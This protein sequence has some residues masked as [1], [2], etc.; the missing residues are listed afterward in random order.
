MSGQIDR[1]FGKTYCLP[2]CHLTN[3]AE[4]LSIPS[5]C[6]CLNHWNIV[7]GKA[8]VPFSVCWGTEE[9]D[10][11][12]WPYWPQLQYLL[13]HRFINM[14]I[15]YI[16]IYI[17]LHQYLQHVFQ[18]TLLGYLTSATMNSLLFIYLAYFLLDILPIDIFICL[19]V[20]LDGQNYWHILA[21]LKSEHEIF[22]RHTCL[23]MSG[24]TG[25]L[26]VLTS[27]AGPDRP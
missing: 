13:N 27:F 15:N 8:A 24:L 6:S 22:F 10:A 25:I 4:R 17:Y 2:T 9:L 12:M 5:P 23:I 21:K 14:S 18:L 7:F 19:S 20:P 3:P 16:Y 26:H 11:L 1:L